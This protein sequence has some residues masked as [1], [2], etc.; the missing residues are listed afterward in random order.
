MLHLK[1]DLLFKNTMR[2]PVLLGFIL[3]MTPKG[4][5]KDGI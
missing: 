4:A 5:Q 1:V 3:N 2:E